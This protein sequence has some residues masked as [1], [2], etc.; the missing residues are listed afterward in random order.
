LDGH[1]PSAWPTGGDDKP[2]YLGP[3]QRLR[4][5]LPTA[6]RLSPRLQLFELLLA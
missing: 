1:L 4:D 5:R 3:R 6:A 2:D